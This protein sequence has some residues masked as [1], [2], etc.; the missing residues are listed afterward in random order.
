MQ[1][2]GTKRSMGRFHKLVEMLRSLSV[3]SWCRSVERKWKIRRQ[4]MVPLVVL[5]QKAR[6][7]QATSDT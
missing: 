4:D 7:G 2:T 1:H 6:V 5:R 3:C